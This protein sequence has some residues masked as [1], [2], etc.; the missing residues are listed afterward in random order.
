MLLPLVTAL[1]VAFPADT[2]RL[3]PGAAIDRAEQASFMVRAAEARAR[4]ASAGIGVA[5]AWPNPTLGFSAENLGAERQVT[6]RDGLAG[7]EG[8]LLLTGWLPLGGDRGA[9]ARRARAVAEGGAQGRIA[10]VQE[11]RLEALDALA[12]WTRERRLAENAAEEAR[13]LER[14]ARSMTLRAGEGRT[15]GGEA[16]RARLEAGLAEARAARRSAAAE[17]AAG[18]LRRVL[19]LG[20][21]SAVALAPSACEPAPDRSGPVPE[22]AQSEAARAAA[23]AALDLTRARAVPDLLPHVGVRRT[24]GYTGLQLGLTLELPLFNVGRAALGQ[25]RA[26]AE[27]AGFLRDDLARRIDAEREAARAA[28]GRLAL[29][30]ARFDA[31]WRADLDRTLSSAQAR[32]D[33]G[34]GT[35]AELLDARRARLSALDEL[36][37]WR[38]ELRTARARLARWSG[39]VI[40]GS[41]FCDHDR[42]G[43]DDP[44]E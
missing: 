15:A 3:T 43:L 14:F 40:D 6:G 19:G 27:A 42:G 25:A 12:A 26:D 20:P 23:V 21:D 8:A 17:L 22:L 10:A 39:A 35:L 37:I 33:A 32:Y 5:R 31:A 44:A 28:A 4:A 1:V 16:A 2:V 41:L 29:A 11:A 24:A 36:E 9:A 7:T 30:G 38:A 13:E 34:E 18:T